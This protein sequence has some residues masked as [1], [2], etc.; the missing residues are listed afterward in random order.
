MLKSDVPQSFYRNP[1]CRKLINVLV[2]LELQ[3]DTFQSYICDECKNHHFRSVD[4]TRLVSNSRSILNSINQPTHHTHR[5]KINQASHGKAVTQ[6]KHRLFKITEEPLKE[7]TPSR[8]HLAY[9]E[10]SS[11]MIK[12]K[13][14]DSLGRIPW[15]NNYVNGERGLSEQKLQSIMNQLTNDIRVN[16]RRVTPLQAQMVQQSSNGEINP[17]SPM[18]DMQDEMQPDMQNS[19]QDDMQN[20]KQND[21]GDNEIK[22]IQIPMNQKGG[23]GKHRP[24]MFERLMFGGLSEIMGGGG[25]RRRRRRWRWRRR[26]RKR[27]R[28]TA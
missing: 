27:R 10:A 23:N 11:S 21:M 14:D 4:N 25:G 2:T 6:A 28:K 12:T 16:G 18:N 7:K 3:S 13:L 26:R 9:N 17:T 8:K 24:G 1:G 5:H 22:P 15:S 20:N 19:M